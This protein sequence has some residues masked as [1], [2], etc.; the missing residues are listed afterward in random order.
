MST[1]K[2]DKLNDDEI[3]KILNNSKSFKEAIET[4]GYST[5]GSGSYTLVNSIL[6]KREI[7][8]PKY[9]IAINEKIKN[10]FIKK[11]L[12]EIL[13]KNSEYTNRQRLKIR[14]IN[15][16]LLEYKCSKCGNNGEW[17]GKTLT[18]QL[19]HKNGINND[20]RLENLEF[21]CPNCHSQT[22]TYAG[23]NRKN[24]KSKKYCECGIEINKSSKMCPKCRNKKLSIKNRKIKN[25]PGIN[26]LLLE[27][28]KY[29]YVAT[30]KKYN[31]S[32]NTIR[33]W[34][35]NSV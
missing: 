16:G 35:K 1:N 29:G 32:D 5:N 6:K 23:K 20:N 13:I 7:N 8:K 11:T 15:E 3:I 34:I 25:R 26:E 30:G 28:E 31:V 18:L 12:S 17:E 21:L 10:K 4:F 2:L 22:K 14:L 33:N 19:E 9:Y 24:K 27:V